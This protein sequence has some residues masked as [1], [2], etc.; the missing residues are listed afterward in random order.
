MSSYEPDVFLRLPEKEIKEKTLMPCPEM[1]IRL[2]F[3][4]TALSAPTGELTFIITRRSIQPRRKEN[5]IAHN[6][7]NARIPP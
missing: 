5:R 2:L 1:L 6:P 3:P 4:P 7:F